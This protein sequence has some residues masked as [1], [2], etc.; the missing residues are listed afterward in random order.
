VQDLVVGVSKRL[1]A[2]TSRRGLF[3]RT[4]YLALGVVGGSALL[5]LTAAPASSQGPY[6]TQAEL[7]A[8]DEALADAALLQAGCCPHWLSCCSPGCFSCGNRAVKVYDCPCKC[9]A[10]GEHCS[11]RYTCQSNYPCNSPDP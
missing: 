4:G 3:A 8:L 11:Y 6:P 7:D 9:R 10:G 2:G 5:Q 1:A